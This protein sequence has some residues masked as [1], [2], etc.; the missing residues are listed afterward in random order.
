MTTVYKWRGAA[1]PLNGKV[2]QAGE[3]IPEEEVAG[4]RNKEALVSA[5]LITVE[6]V[7]DAPTEKGSTD[8][9][10]GGAGDEDA[11]ASVPAPSSADDAADDAVTPPGSDEAP[12]PK[13]KSTRKRSTRSSSGE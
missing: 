13:K 4:L 3:V 5:G 1:R 2:R 6:Y 11:G 9:P 12:K 10:D 7:T 8:S